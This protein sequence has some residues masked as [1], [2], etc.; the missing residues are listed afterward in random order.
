MAPLVLTI[1]FVFAGCVGLGQNNEDSAQQQSGLAELEVNNGVATS[2]PQHKTGMACSA[3]YVDV[4]NTHADFINL[5]EDRWSFVTKEG[6]T[7]EPWGVE[8]A[9]EVAPGKTVEVT[10]AFRESADLVVESLR[11]LLPDGTSSL[12]NAVHFDATCSGLACTFTSNGIFASSAF[13]WTF[14]DGA[15][16]YG[17]DQVRHEF[18]NDLPESYVV[19]LKV[20]G[21]EFSIHVFCS[22]SFGAKCRP[23]Y[24]I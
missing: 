1:A 24:R 7:Y 6:G 8:G 5:K 11:L 9:T 15:T 23:M 17:S 12:A 4:T 18:P 19:K 10:I 22:D 2:C 20:S 21:Q 16:E 14:G 3:F 13:A